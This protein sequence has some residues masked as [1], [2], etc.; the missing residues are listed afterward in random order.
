MEYRCFFWYLQKIINEPKKETDE[1]EQLK[2]YIANFIYQNNENG[3]TVMDVVTD[4]K[5]T[6][7]VGIVRGYG[8][9]ETVELTGE[10][11]THPIYQK[12]FKITSLRALAPEDSVAIERYL[13]SGAIKGIGEALAAR[14]VKTFGEDTFRITQEEPERL[15][16]VKGISLK[17]AYDI[18]GQLAEKRDMRDAMIFLQQY[19]INQNL[20]NKIYMQY[21]MG[22]YGIMKENPYRLAEDISGVGF[23]IADEIAEKCGIS[24]D[25]DYRIRCGLLHALLQTT[26][27]GNCFFPKELLLEKTSELLQLSKEHIL[28]HLDSLAMEKK[29][30][31]KRAEEEERVYAASY[32]YEE[33]NCAHKL[34]ELRDTYDHP[35]C[36]K[37]MD[38]LKKE[39]LRIEE[40]ME[41]ELDE[42]QREAVAECMKAGVFVLTGGP[43]TGK[44]TTL[45]TIIRFLVMEGM[46]FYL[47]A[48]TGRAAKRMTETTGYE[49]KTIHRLLE[50]SGEISEE[51]K[52]VSFERN[53]ENPLEADA[54]I[55]DEMSMVDIHLLKALLAAILPGTKLILV[56]D[57]DQLHSVGPGQVLRDILESSCFRGVRLEKIFRQEETSHIVSNAFK[58]NHGQ[59]IDFTEKYPDFFLLEKSEPDVIYYY[60]E[61]LMVNKLP[62]NFGIDI[63]DT[64]ILTPMRKGALGV[65]ALNVVLQERL[66]PRDSRKKEHKHG[67][68]LFREGDKVMQIRNNYDLEWEILGKYNIAV[69]SGKGVFNGDMGRIQKID[70]FSKMVDVKFEDERLVKLPFEMLDEI[71]LAYAV[72]IHKSQGS[73]YP[74]VI[75]PVL[76][77]PKMLLTRN[78]LYTAVTRARDSVI[79]LGSAKTIEEMIGTDM[80]Q[81]RYTSLKEKLVEFGKIS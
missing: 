43:G 67:E 27:D 59:Q 15:A 79:I 3:Y 19:G 45:N 73:E 5:K 54:V 22:L 49:A 14:I 16:E 81:K 20:A 50:L 33:L 36:E 38:T 26:M 72:T 24:V 40:S 66:N 30:V 69:E 63:L 10:Y 39:I 46:D 42:L 80:V 51:N 7:C 77:G 12:Q 18:A 76:T 6:T 55:V 56:G 2:G 78:L 32:Y 57:V 28:P 37:S 60:I 41:M 47:A 44:T 8:E 21:G 70:E 71:E 53:E 25:S 31:I 64:Q 35:V 23:K 1:M 29:I 52:R 9:G 74:V 65:E 48:P 13:G 11:V 68:T 34:V 17:K 75:L 4:G 58:I 61:Q 62:K